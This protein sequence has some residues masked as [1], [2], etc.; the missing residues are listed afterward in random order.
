MDKIRLF[1]AVFET[2]KLEFRAYGRTAEQ[3]EL[4]LIAGWKRYSKRNNAD[5][6][7]LLRYWDGVNTF[8]IEEGECYTDDEDKT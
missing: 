5:Q 3:A 8:E 2:R 7:Y 4:A 1:V 6:H